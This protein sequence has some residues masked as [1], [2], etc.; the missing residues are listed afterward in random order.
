MVV[1]NRPKLNYWSTSEKLFL[2]MRRRMHFIIRVQCNFLGKF[3]SFDAKWIYFS[4][5]C[6][7]YSKIISM[8][9]ININKTEALIFSQQLTIYVILIRLKSVFLKNVLGKLVPRP[10]HVFLILDFIFYSLKKEKKNTWITP[11]WLRYTIIFWNQTNEIL[12]WQAWF[13]STTVRFN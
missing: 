2:R 11:T 10:V 12:A 8:V 13:N 5:L 6:R 4:D 3:I 9:F 7:N 1:E